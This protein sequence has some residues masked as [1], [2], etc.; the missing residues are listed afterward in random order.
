M[1]SSM[2]GKS[3][4]VASLRDAVIIPEARSEDGVFSVDVLLHHPQLGRV[5]IEVDG[6]FHFMFNDPARFNA[7]AR[8]NDPA[9]FNGKTLVRNR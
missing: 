5:G 1:L 9:R 4:S 7:P 3:G 2:T 6:P 8:F